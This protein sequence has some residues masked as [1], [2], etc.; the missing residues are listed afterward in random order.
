MGKLLPL[1]I[2]LTTVGSA[3][4]SKHAPDNLERLQKRYFDLETAMGSLLRR[5]TALYEDLDEMDG[6][7]VDMANIC[8]G[9]L[10]LTAATAVTTS[11]ASGSPLRYTPYKGNTCAIYDSTNTKWVL[12]K[13]SE[14]NLPLAS[15]SAGTNYDVFLYNNAGALTI[16]TF[17]AWTNNTTR[18]TGLVSQDGVLVK[19]GDTTRRYV[20]TFRATAANATQDTLTQRFVWNY[21]NRVQRKLQLLPTTDNWTY[22]TNGWRSTA[23]SATNR[24]ELVIGVAD[25]LLEMRTMQQATGSANDQTYYSSGV[26]MDT[27]TNVTSH[28]RG[29]GVDDNIT[30]QVWSEYRDYPPLGYH[31]FQWVERSTGASVTLWGDNGAAANYQGGMLGEFGG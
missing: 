23:N 5:F 27:T 6:R 18:A 31:Y 13:F 15:L 10:T 2:L 4:P 11:D 24:V 28:L 12:L 14:I 16:D 8:E 19:S 30:N 22:V 29:S 25:V 9:R 1:L 20:G 3:S 17:V 7:V 26:G 21:Q